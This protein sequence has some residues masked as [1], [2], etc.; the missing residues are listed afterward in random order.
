MKLRLLAILAVGSAAACGGAPVSEVAADP[1]QPLPGLEDAEAGRFLLGKAVFERLVVQE[2]GLGPLFNADRCSSCHNIP[3]TGGSGTLTVTKATRFVADRCDLLEAEGGDNI[4]QKATPLLEAHGVHGETVPADATGRATI[5]APPLYGL[6]LVE[7]MDE[8]GILRRADPDDADGD[9]ISGR[10]GR[11]AD[12]RLARF[13]R[14]ADVA[15]LEGFIDTA[16]R[17]EIGLTTPGHPQEER[18]NGRPLPPGVDPMRDPEIDDNGIGRLADYIRFL[19]PP[20][21]ERASGTAS[22]S[23]RR[24]SR[25]FERLRCDA[26]HTPSMRTGTGPAA[27]LSGVEAS[28]YS[29][30]LLHDMGP[31]LADVCG[32]D[33]SPSEWRTTTLWGLRYRNRL[34]H[35]GRATDIQSAI[36]LHAGEATAARD[37]FSR[38]SADEQADLLRFL[39]SL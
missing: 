20:A 5:E 3:A 2:E 34:L 16:L 6:G 26:C 9:G 24:G 35:D 29:D 15:T 21:R 22:D 4:Q 1:G 23:I 17:F 7:A 11:D 13:S 12:G 19:A 18:I 10:A 27:S 33:A 37:A 25:V 14:K 39:A 31:A 32:H 38:L 28:L 8:R 36:L 30:L